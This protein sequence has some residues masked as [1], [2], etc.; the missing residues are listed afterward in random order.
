M[1][2]PVQTCLHERVW[3]MH[4]G[5]SGNP[6][7]NCC[8][9]ASSICICIRER[10]D[11]DEARQEPRVRRLRPFCKHQVAEDPSARPAKRLI[12][13]FAIGVLEAACT[14]VVVSYTA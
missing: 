10:E 13:S 9:Q 11:E 12:C 2:M 8:C 4:F 14:V 1:L 3:S 7:N 5:T 6:R